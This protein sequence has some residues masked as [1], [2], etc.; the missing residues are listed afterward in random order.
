[1]VQAQFS[2]FSHNC[3]GTIACPAVVALLGALG[4]AILNTGDDGAWFTYFFPFADTPYPVPAGRDTRAFPYCAV[5][6]LPIPAE[7][8]FFDR[9]VQVSRLIGSKENDICKD[10]KKQEEKDNKGG[11]FHCITCMRQ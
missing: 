9:I 6:L 1:L 10:G 7:P 5:L 2:L 8:G 3:A 11:I 4:T